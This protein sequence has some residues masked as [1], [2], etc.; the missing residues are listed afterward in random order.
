MFCSL[1]PSGA[2][3]AARLLRAAGTVSTEQ[4]LRS[5]TA[6]PAGLSLDPWG[7]GMKIPIH[8]ARRHH[9]WHPSPACLVA[10]ESPSLI[11][12]VCPRTSPNAVHLRDRM[13]ACG[14]SVDRE[15]NWF[16][17]SRLL[18][19]PQRRINESHFSAKWFNPMSQ[20]S[21]EHTSEL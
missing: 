9:R 6:T 19:P 12:P 17:R 8:Q 13:I 11:H 16:P 1:Q 4:Y 7:K 3:S 2:S 18:V 21:E 10:W 14:R 20:R 5:S 15:E